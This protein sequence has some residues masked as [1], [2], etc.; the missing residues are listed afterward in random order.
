MSKESIQERRSALREQEDSATS[1]H[2]K[3][4]NLESSSK[5]IPLSVDSTHNDPSQKPSDLVI[6]ST[7]DTNENPY[8]DDDDDYLEFKLN[9]G[10]QEGIMRFGDSENNSKP[11]MPQIVRYSLSDSNRPSPASSPYNADTF[12][13]YTKMSRESSAASNPSLHSVLSNQ[14]S[15]SIASG[16]EHPSTPIRA[17]PNIYSSSARSSVDYSPKPSQQS[18]TQYITP[19]EEHS[20]R[21]A[22][23]KQLEDEQGTSSIN[24]ANSARLPDTNSPLHDSTLQPSTHS[25]PAS[26]GPQHE[27]PENSKND[28]LNNH[29][30]SHA[31]EQQ[32]QTTDSDDELDWQEMP[33]VASYDVYNEKG[34]KVVIRNEDHNAEFE[35]LA[36]YQDGLIGGAKY[37]YTRVTRDDDQRSIDSLDETTDYLFDED[38]YKRNPISQLEAT[39]NIL[40]DSQR[41]AYVGLCQ[42]AMVEMATNLAQL[43]GSWR[44][45]R[46]LSDSQKSLGK[47]SQ[48]MLSRLYMHMDISPEEQKMMQLLSNHGIE[49]SDLAPSLLETARVQNPFANIQSDSQKKATDPAS[50]TGSETHDSHP[51]NSVDD[52]HYEN[53]EKYCNDQ[54][55]EID[56]R[57]TILCDL[58][59]VLISDSIYDSRSRALLMHVGK[60]LNIQKTEVCQF[61]KKVSEALEIDDAGKQIWRETEIMEERRKKSLKKKYMYVGLATIGGGLILGLSAGLLAPVIG[62][63]IAAG[64]STV[65]I[66]G[67]AG[68]LAGA[69]GTAI[70]TSTGV[71]VGSKIG[72]QGM[73]KRMGHV[74]TFEFRPL[75]NNKRVNLIL[76][77]SGW[78]IG[79]E[80]DV[81]LPFSTTDPIMG[82]LYSLL[83]EPDM[84]RSM[85]QTINILATEI[86]TQSIQQILG[87]TILTALMASIQLPM[88]L[89]KLGYLLDNPW[90]VS[91]DRAWASGLILADT[92]IRRN[93]GTRPITLVGFSL[94]AR[95]IYSCLVELARQGAHGLIE[96]VLL[97]GAPIVVKK[98]QLILARSVVGGRFVNGYSKKDWILGYL[99][100]ATSGG[101]G[102]IAGL[103]AVKGISGVE[104]L[105]CTDD[106]E[107]HMGYRIAMPVLLSKLGWEVSSEEF[108]EI[109]NP[110]P[111][112]QRERQRQ[113][114]EEFDVAKKSMEKEISQ[115][116]RKKK[117][118]LFNWL[119]PKE[120]ELWDMYDRDLKATHKQEKKEAKAARA[121]L[122]EE[123]KA[124]GEPVLPPSR[125]STTVSEASTPSLQQQNDP[126]NTIF[127]VD[128][129]RVELEKLAASNP[130]L[131]P[132]P[133]GKDH[134]IDFSKDEV[135]IDRGAGVRSPED[136]SE[137]RGKGGQVQMSFDDPF[138]DDEYERNGAKSV[139]YTKSLRQSYEEPASTGPA[140]GVPM[141]VANSGNSIASGGDLAKA[142]G[143]PANVV[144]P[145]RASEISI[146]LQQSV[147]SPTVLQS[148]L[149]PSFDKTQ[150]S[151]KQEKE[152]RLQ[153]PFGD[154][155]DEDNHYGYNCDAGIDENVANN[156]VQ[157]TPITTPHSKLAGYDSY[158]DIG[159]L[160]DAG[161][162]G[163]NYSKQNGLTATKSIETS[164]PL[165]LST[166]S[167]YSDKNV[168]YDD[169]EYDDDEFGFGKPNDKIKMTFD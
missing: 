164:T 127:D 151:H 149:R 119:K 95:V 110:D 29:D 114:I 154:D 83:W 5:T 87:S 153:N 56:I 139:D 57:W 98:D 41:I 53:P 137:P 61:E 97:F 26:G 104:N 88:A 167:P 122:R 8:D 133:D 62:A 48:L 1:V 145:S 28:P 150:N 65:G 74:K 123:Q 47:W 72:L 138:M 68:F 59:L 25:S 140:T 99:F 81:R 2:N 130:N 43:H 107:G 54:T 11:I 4:P 6:P 134:K 165:S 120:K 124:K 38:E 142:R 79:K 24:S 132:N 102:T 116:K 155:D 96:D 73:N 121:R 44:I 9:N 13:N 36:S 85:G 94:G 86:L 115:G 39:K 146:P 20:N 75:H 169:Y 147:A 90:N 92:L 159:N 135:P 136:E 118:S 30:D 105:D 78:L 46:K 55:I 76:T 143:T 112:Q 91:L 161:D 3:S 27:H 152:R 77:V 111:E 15:N 45:A 166:K 21:L 131:V 126:S 156:K 67:T 23:K 82:D 19:Q 157:S 31:L 108:E 106:V 17:F 49:A 32:Q 66:S 113:L 64:L 50:P 58:F 51:I 160:G 35:K 100:R 37:D 101:L 80:D 162:I 34:K 129:I 22:R 10:S 70:V 103:A 125:E 144:I 14:C 163:G 128:A 63:G 18:H 89:S 71:A 12:P 84:L 141:T 16:S 7:A 33:T 168:G 52:L 60:Y 40:T 158:G 42:L 93:L 109:E 148:P 69:G 117:S